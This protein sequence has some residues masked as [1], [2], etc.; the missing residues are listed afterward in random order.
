ML[1]YEL[2]QLPVIELDTGLCDNICSMHICQ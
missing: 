1:V 2:K